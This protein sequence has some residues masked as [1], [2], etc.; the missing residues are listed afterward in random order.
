MSD[1][2]ASGLFT[3]ARKEC[4]LKTTFNGRRR[5]GA[6][7]AHTAMVAGLIRMCPSPYNE[8][9]GRDFD[10]NEIPIPA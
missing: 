3:T 7:P 10:A 4:V 5:A 1:T 6:V 8:A 2:G 9:V